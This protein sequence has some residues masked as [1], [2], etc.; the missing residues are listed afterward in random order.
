MSF[1]AEVKKELCRLPLAEPGAAL[2]EA[3]GVL[4]YANSFR[5]DEIRIITGSPDFAERLPKLFRRAFSLGFDRT[6]ANRTGSKRSFYI[7]DPEKIAAV[8]ARFG[9]EP[10]ST[11][12]HHV[13]LGI[14]EEES[15]RVAFVRGAFFAGGS[16]TDPEKNYH[17]ELATAHRSVSRET[18]S[19]LL[20]LGFQAK[21]STRSGNYINYFK[22][23]E[24]MEDLLTTL[25]APVSA[26]RIM[27]AKVEKDMRNA[28]NRKINCDTANADKIV[29]AAQQQLEDIRRIDRLQG[30]DELPDKLYETALLRIANPEASLAELAVLSDPPV[31]KSCLSHRLRK[32]SELA[33]ALPE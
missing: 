16:V 14:L 27:S 1:S 28:I 19:I 26:M 12:A 5:A 3:Y 15:E 13:N 11:L 24:V 4:L 22:Q 29:S 10:G 18:F 31:T 30:L 8:F 20:E 17:M 7:T 9:C 21:E 2:A 23:S 32:L 6:E 33:A 25:G